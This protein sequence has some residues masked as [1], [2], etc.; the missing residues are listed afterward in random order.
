MNVCCFSGKLA[1]PSQLRH[2]KSRLPVC[3]AGLLVRDVFVS[4]TATGPLAEVLSKMKEGQYAQIT[5]SLASNEWTSRDGD[6]RQKFV[7]VVT[8]IG[9]GDAAIAAESRQYEETDP[10]ENA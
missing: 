2:T 4:L 1:H 9:S 7:I 10:L 8:A 3:N 5:G 6:R